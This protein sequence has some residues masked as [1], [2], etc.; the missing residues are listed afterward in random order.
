M[1]RAS[2]VAGSGRGVGRPKAGH[3][4]ASLTL[5]HL[6]RRFAQFRRR[7][8]GRPRIPDDLRAEVLSALDHGLT[9]GQLRQACGVTPSQVDDWRQFQGGAV[10]AGVS[11]ADPARIFSVDDGPPVDGVEAVM[12]GNGPQELELRLGGWSISL[13]HEAP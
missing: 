5:D 10:L 4:A 8:R 9:L 1:D 2:H 12:A 11:S 7:R 6:R 13:R 3:T